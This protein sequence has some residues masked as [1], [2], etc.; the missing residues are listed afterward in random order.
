MQTQILCLTF[1]SYLDVY[2]NILPEWPS[3]P[4]MLTDTF[5][6]CSMSSETVM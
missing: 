5:M 2:N 4:L 1:I 3:T 6:I